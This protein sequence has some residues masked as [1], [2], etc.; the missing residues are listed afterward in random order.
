MPLKDTLQNHP[1]VIYGGVAVVAFTMGIAAY[2]QALR[3]TDRKPIPA[4][5][6][7]RLAKC[8]A[9]VESLRVADNPAGLARCTAE[10]EGLKKQLSA[11]TSYAKRYETDVE[12]LRKQL[13][14]AKSDAWIKQQ[15]LI[16]ASAPLAVEFAGAK[17]K[18]DPTCPK[19]TLLVTEKYYMED[20][21]TEALI[22]I[23]LG[24]DFKPAFLSRPMD[25]GVTVTENG[26]TL[27]SCA[28]GGGTRKFYRRFFNIKTGAASESILVEYKM[29]PY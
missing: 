27:T 18:R 5:D 29:Q 14:Q 8:D 16:A 2:D 4:S 21:G 22:A 6:I 15:T 17:S 12:K 25:G 3:L 23:D 20:G 26:W 11:A 13:D 7:A 19:G 28:A 1:V 24:M 10:A 9:S